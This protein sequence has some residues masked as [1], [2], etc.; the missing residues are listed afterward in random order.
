MEKC[1]ILHYFNNLKIVRFLS[2]I[3]LND[4]QILSLKVIKKLNINDCPKF[5][6]NE[7]EKIIE[8]FKN[9]YKNKI[10]SKLDDFIFEN[11]EDNIKYKIIRKYSE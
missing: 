7:S 4:N 6:I 2:K 9:L 8:Y 3:L 1:D 11:F 10:N 5:D